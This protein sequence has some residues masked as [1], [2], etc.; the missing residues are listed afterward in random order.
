LKVLVLVF[1]KIS[2]YPLLKEKWS[3]GILEQWIRKEILE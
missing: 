3:S 2:T 1:Q